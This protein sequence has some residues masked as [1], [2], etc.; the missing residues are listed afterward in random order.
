MLERETYVNRGCVTLINSVLSS[1]PLY[2]MSFFAIP[3]VMLKK[4]DYFCSR[5]FLA[6]RKPKE[7]VSPCQVEHTL[8]AKGSRG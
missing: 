2:M 1:L 6:K 7:K 4:L 8:V 3:R 5:F